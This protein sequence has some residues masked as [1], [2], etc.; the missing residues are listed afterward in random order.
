MCMYVCMYVHVYICGYMYACVIICACVLLFFPVP[1]STV[2]S[3][4]TKHF[5]KKR[6]RRTNTRVYETFPEDICDCLYTTRGVS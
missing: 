5:A 2:I 6:K 4:C 3:M 1:P